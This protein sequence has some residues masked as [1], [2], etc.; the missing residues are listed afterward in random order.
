MAD[1]FHIE[2]ATPNPPL[3]SLPQNRI[4]GLLQAY[5]QVIRRKTQQNGILKPLEGIYRLPLVE[6]IEEQRSEGQIIS[7]H[8]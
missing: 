5:S 2:R 7:N 4:E 3:Q 6:S 8:F 1:L